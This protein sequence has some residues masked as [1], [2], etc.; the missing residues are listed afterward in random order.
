MIPIKLT[1][2]GLY[3]YQ[4]ERPAVIDFAKL[5]EGRLFGIFGPVGA[6]KSALLEA[7][8]FS[9]Y[10][11]TERLNQREKRGYNMMNLKSDRLEISFEF[12]AESGRYKFEVE[13]RRNSKN[14]EDIRSFDRK[15]YRWQALAE[16]GGEWIPLET[17][18]A[19]E[20]LGLSYDH[21][22]KT[23]IIPQGKFQEFLHMSTTDR[24]RMLQDLFALDRF[25]LAAPTKVL[26]G[27]AEHLLSALEGQLKEL[28]EVPEEEIEK[29][30]AKSSELSAELKKLEQ[31]EGV[32]KK[33]NE[34]LARV[35][36]LRDSLI[37]VRDM[38]EPLEE[39]E[40]S[41][42]QRREDLQQYQLLKASFQE[43]LSRQKRLQK[44]LQ[45]RKEVA[46]KLESK[47]ER[48]S[49]ALHS[50]EAE[51]AE[52]Q[53]DYDDRDRLRIEADE[54]EKMAEV[55]K[56]NGEMAE[57]E[58]RL[59]KGGEKVAEQEKALERLQAQIAER[60]AT[61]NELRKSLPDLDLLRENR[62]WLREKDRR[63]AD[64]KAAAKALEDHAVEE[65]SSGDALAAFLVQPA[66]QQPAGDEIAPLFPNP[67]QPQDQ[68]LSSLETAL[69]AFQDRISDRENELAKAR[70][71]TGLAAYAQQIQPGE[72]CPLCG[73]TD[74]PAP[75]HDADQQDRISQLQTS[76]DRLRE[77]QRAL[78]K[79]QP[80][81]LQHIENRRQLV[82]RGEELAAVRQQKED[83]AKAWTS[84]RG[85]EKADPKALAQQI[86]QAGLQSKRIEELRQQAAQ[87]R[88]EEQKSRADLERFRKAIEGIRSDRTALQAKANTLA[89]QIDR[90]DPEAWSGHDPRQLQA[91][92][93]QR[94]QAHEAIL[95]R[96][97][98]LQEQLK[99]LREQD[100][101]LRTQLEVNREGLRQS[102]EDLRET[103][104]SLA[105]KLKQAG[106]PDL[107]SVRAILA[108]NIDE[109]NE[110]EEIERYFERLTNLKAEFTNLAKKLEGQPYDEA[111]HA[112]VLKRLSEIAQTRSAINQELGG[113]Q[114]RI[115]KMKSDLKKRESLLAEQER[116]GSRLSNLKDLAGL[117]K[118]SGFVKYVSTIYLR[119]LA[120]RANARFQGLTRNRLSLE[121]DEEN[122]FIVRDMLNDGRTRS[123]KTLSG[124]QTFQA[125]F[126]LALALADNIHDRTRSQHNFFFLDEGFGTLD[127]ES[128]DTV[129]ETLKAL[130]RENR[131]VGVISHVKELQ[132]EIDLAITISQDEEYGSK[133]KP[134]W[135]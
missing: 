79:L 12:E 8:T 75:Y 1:V 43:S 7:I 111:R 109:Q 82:R 3:S 115:K 27:E 28:P 76:L 64:W 44:A 53:K 62:D 30:E 16:D 91:A 32:L 18:D 17:T 113:L 4:H 89:E 130:R 83:H 117:F 103:D 49:K 34:Q 40:G 35:K 121:I 108:K 112:V 70:S 41:F 125:A 51:L 48:S 80:K 92:A 114:E 6:G 68:L 46:Q 134:S 105:D 2:A 63:E 81:L 42:K 104:A 10:G 71:Q 69:H 131:I 87:F 59:E 107:D 20:V 120:E 60:E 65:R 96:H 126:S 124:G 129:F 57:L 25:D 11:Q 97:Q 90:L 22:T 88:T 101:T 93:Q 132:E 37:E 78:Q 110:K 58:G 9:L 94:L 13:G 135:V 31:E 127:P 21:F 100:Q 45:E 106:L 102:S 95:K 55:R 66:L 123:V 5:T 67:N 52:S 84:D 14:F 116:L 29:R 15:A 98:S 122:Q 54:L 72:P 119:E 86:E 73:A 118:S 99:S 128:L 77:A 133:V 26:I 61:G 56:L 47:L 39:E 19:T 85:F 23:I 50:K 74:H 38:L 33:E 36:E 24:T